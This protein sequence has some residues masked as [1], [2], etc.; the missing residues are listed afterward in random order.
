MGTGVWLFH[1][2]AAELTALVGKAHGVD[3]ASMRNF[4]PTEGSCLPERL[5]RQMGLAHQDLACIAVSDPRLR[6]ATQAVAL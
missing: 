4:Q 1:I 5:C 2:G 6:K 3:V